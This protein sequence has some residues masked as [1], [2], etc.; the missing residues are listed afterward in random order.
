MSFAPFVR[1]FQNFADERGLREGGYW[2]EVDEVS[3][4]AY[5]WVLSLLGF[6]LP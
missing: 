4:E 5:G 3:G 2:G 6:P 1:R